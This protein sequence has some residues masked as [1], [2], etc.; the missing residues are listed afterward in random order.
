MQRAAF[1]AKMWSSADQPRINQHP[2][3]SDGW[4][5]ESQTHYSPIWFTGDQLPNS[6]VPEQDEI[7][8]IDNQDECD[9]ASV[10]NMIC[11]LSNNNPY[12]KPD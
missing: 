10:L 6:F 11:Y 7:E 4:T 12:P 2:V 8:A 1:I 5:L 3:E 9:M